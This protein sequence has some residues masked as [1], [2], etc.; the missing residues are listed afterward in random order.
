MRARVGA[1]GV[2]RQSFPE[3]G[4]KAGKSQPALHEAVGGTK[5]NRPATM[6]ELCQQIR[7]G[8]FG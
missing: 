2:D 6:G 5:P 3:V 1:T 4:N 7:Q 8:L